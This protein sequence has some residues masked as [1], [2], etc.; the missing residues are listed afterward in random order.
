MTGGERQFTTGVELINHEIRYPFEQFRF[1]MEG[2]EFPEVDINL[3][4]GLHDRLAITSNGPYR[5]ENELP[6]ASRIAR[7]SIGV[8]VELHSGLIPE[9]KKEEVAQALATVLFDIHNIT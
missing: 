8:R 2:I 9:G 5:S 6:G 4:K 7:P 1:L 3:R